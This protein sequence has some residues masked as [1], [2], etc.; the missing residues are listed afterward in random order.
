ML[1]KYTN[2]HGDRRE[3]SMKLNRQNI[4]PTD[5]IS[6]ETRDDSQAIQLKLTHGN[7]KATRPN[8]IHIET[9]VYNALPRYL[10]N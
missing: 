5:L 3:S 1:K 9:E 7:M 6:E 8:N 10:Q 4:L 2:T